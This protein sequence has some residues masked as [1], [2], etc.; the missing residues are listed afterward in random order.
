MSFYGGSS[1]RWPNYLGKRPHNVKTTKK[2][3]TLLI[4]RL[5]VNRRTF[6]MEIPIYIEFSNVQN[7]KNLQKSDFSNQIFDFPQNHI[8]SNAITNSD[9][10]TNVVTAVESNQNRTIVNEP[11]T[12]HTDSYTKRQI[13]VYISSPAYQ[14][15]NQ[16]NHT[17]LCSLHK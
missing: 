1:C 7:K 11:N 6:S 4:S 12:I 2:Q 10:P 5:W 3:W 13:F 8:K 15:T 14:P 9:T 16:P 17:F